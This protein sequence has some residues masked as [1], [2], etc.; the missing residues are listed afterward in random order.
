LLGAG[1]GLGVGYNAL[2]IGLNHILIASLFIFTD[3]LKYDD[4]IL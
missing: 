2:I 3:S 1:S 4:F